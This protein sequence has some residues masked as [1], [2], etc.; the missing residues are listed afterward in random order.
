M[1]LILMIML[2]IYLLF[3]SLPNGLAELT[4][5]A[6][7]EFYQ[8]WWNACSVEDFYS[9]WL[10]ISYLFYYRHV[11]RRLIDQYNMSQIMAKALTNLISSAMQELMMVSTINS[12]WL[13]LDR[14]C[15]FKYTAS[16]YSKRSLLPLLGLIFSKSINHLIMKKWMSLS[17]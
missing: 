15:A 17:C 16:I 14:S 10:R 8:D 13:F 5:F 2:M 12:N 3:E 11:Y 4:L 6:D 9:K 1:P 7:R